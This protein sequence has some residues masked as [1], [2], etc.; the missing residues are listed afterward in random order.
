MWVYVKVCWL[1]VNCEVWPVCSSPSRAF[2]AWPVCS[3]PSKA[4]KELFCHSKN[5]LLFPEQVPTISVPILSSM[6][7]LL[8]QKGCLAVA[9]DLGM[10]MPWERECMLMF[11]VSTPAKIT[12][13]S[14]TAIHRVCSFRWIQ[15]RMFDLVNSFLKK[16]SL[17][18]KSNEAESRLTD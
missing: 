2:E 1:C 15:K 11:F 18:L 14:K 13:F 6:T 7:Q 8:R 5:K 12:L 17:D 4:R 16:D 3:S 9:E 10:K